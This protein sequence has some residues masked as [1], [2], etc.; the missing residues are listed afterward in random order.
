MKHV[1]PGA[2]LPGEIL[3]LK[4]RKPGGESIAVRELIREPATVFVFLRHFG[5]V[6][7]SQHITEWKARIPEFTRVGARLIFA[8]PG[9]V[10]RLEAFVE[11]TGLQDEDVD[12]LTDPT[13]SFQRA[14]GLHR[15]II[16]TIG[17]GSLWTALRATGQG[18][19][20]TRVEGDPFQQGGLLI[21]DRDRR[22]S[23]LH[24]ERRL[25]DHLDLSDV[26]SHV[27]AIIPLDHQTLL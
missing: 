2:P 8:G 20:Q 9:E 21:L 14:L 1:A 26:L 23:L 4:L 10:R 24:R 27:L 5:C 13:L 25:G 6:A 11:R 17:P 15:S 22:V 19:L 16:R 7:C 12:A 18:H 3:E